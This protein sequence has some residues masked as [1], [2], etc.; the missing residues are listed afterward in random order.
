MALLYNIYSEIFD[1]CNNAYG[2]FLA[3]FLCMCFSSSSLKSV[4]TIILS[5]SVSYES[6]ETVAIHCNTS[7]YLYLVIFLQFQVVLLVL[8]NWISAVI[9]STYC[10]MVSDQSSI[11]SMISLLQNSP[12]FHMLLSMV[13]FPAWLLKVSVWFAVLLQNFSVIFLHYALW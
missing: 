6:T 5:I 10:C 2:W 8:C 7:L 4:G 3:I 11:S 12:M 13:S 1:I 9:I